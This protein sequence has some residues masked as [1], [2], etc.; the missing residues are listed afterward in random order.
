MTAKEY[1]ISQLKDPWPEATSVQ[2][3]KGLIAYYI[4]MR[5]GTEGYGFTELEGLIRSCN[6]NEEFIEKCTCFISNVNNYHDLRPLVPNY[7]KG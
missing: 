5:K 4:Q 6:L 1:L 3:R 2:T 7:L